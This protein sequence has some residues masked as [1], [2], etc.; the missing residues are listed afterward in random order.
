[1]AR[2][3]ERKHP[4]ADGITPKLKIENGYWYVSYDKEHQRW[5]QLGRA[6]GEDGAD[7]APGQDGKPGED[8]DPMFQDIDYKT[9]SDYVIFTLFD[10]TTIKLPT[11]GAFEALKTLCNQMNTNISSL[12]T[13]VTA[14]QDNDYVKS[15]SPVMQDNKEVGYTITFSKSNPITIYHGKDGQDGK[16]GTDGKPG[17]DGHVPVIGVKQDEDGLYYWTLDG[18]WLTDD[19]GNKIK[20][21]G[22][23]GQDGKPGEDGQPGTP[24]EDGTPGQ[25]GNPGADGITPKLKI[26]NG[27]W[28]VSY[29][30]RGQTASRRN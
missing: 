3:I 16:P 29:D 5:E 7:G 1:M 18:D 22:T 24:G 20:A 17:E 19:A 10:G 6:T 14:L 9:S 27:Y 15:V 4:G 2:S 11:W 8:G 23:D 21:Q 25:D 28:Y 26:E 13:I 12:Q 30:I